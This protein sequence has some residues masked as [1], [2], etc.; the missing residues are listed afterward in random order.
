MIAIPAIDIRG[1]RV[2]RL[3]QGRFSDETV[4][5]ESPVDVA[6]RWEACGAGMIHVVDLDGAREGA[7]KNLG[8][9]RQIAQAVR[10]KVE[11]GGGIRDE[12]AIA[13]AIDAGVSSVVIGTR[14]LDERFLEGALRR[15]GDKIVVGIDASEGIVVTEGWVH[16]T[17]ATALELARKV[18]SLGV[19]TII[20]TDV[21]KDG[22]LGGPNIGSLKE[23]VSATKMDVVLAG[24]ISSV[25]D[26]RRLKGLGLGN[27][28][29]VIIGKALYEG[30]V[31]L[32]EAIAACKGL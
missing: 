32:G 7:P 6:K 29:G 3:A 11:L 13:S 17:K 12:A 14:A 5:G 31:D 26:I 23:L 20:Y 22:M 9:A 28:A 18:E 27:L 24:G 25:D 30:R 2:V 4:Y 21:S 19:R 10:A 8:L 1:G 16:K 15:F